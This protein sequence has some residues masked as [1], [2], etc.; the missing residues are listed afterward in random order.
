M[1]IGVMAAGAVG[2]Y[3][4]GQLAAAG[5]E[6]AFI[7]RGAHRDAIHREGLKIESALGDLHLSMLMSPM[8]RGRLARSTS[9]YSRSS[10]G[11]PRRRESNPAHSS[12]PTP[13]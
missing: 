2:G 5:H 10:C 8:T 12:A 11:T 13:A 1:R 4:G 6:V 3:F 7:A 9:C